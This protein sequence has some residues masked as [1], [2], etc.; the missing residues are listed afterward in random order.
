VSKLSM[1]P[2]RIII[3]LG[4]GAVGIA[5]SGS[6]SLGNGNSP[7][8]GGSA[9]GGSG[10]AAG[11]ASPTYETCEQTCLTD[12]PGGSTEYQAYR[13]CALC[14]ACHDIC[15]ADIPDLCTDSSGVELGCSAIADSCG[16]CVQSTCAAQQKPDLSFTGHCATQGEACAKKVECVQLNNCIATCMGPSGSGGGSSSGGAGG[17]GGS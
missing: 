10:S 13:E 17:A 1:H 7:A 3:G 12:H 5:C 9:Q 6:D 8:G 11:G 15:T 16:E 14:S 2:W 4:V